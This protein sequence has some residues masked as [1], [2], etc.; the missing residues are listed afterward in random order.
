LPGSATSVPGVAA[1]VELEQ[2][3]DAEPRQLAGFFDRAPERRSDAR[4]AL[5]RRAL[6]STETTVLDTPQLVV[7]C[8]PG[9]AAPR[10]ADHP[11]C[12]VDGYVHNAGELAGQLELPPGSTQE[13]TLLA[14]FAR[15]GF[16]MLERLRGEFAFVLWDPVARRGMLA[17]DQLGTRLLVLR[18][19][20]GRLWFASEVRE[21]LRLL[22]RRPSPDQSSLAN[23]LVMRSPADGCTMFEG[24]R[25]LQPGHA[26]LLDPDG[27]RV[28]RYWA[29]RYHEPLR[30]S[31]QEL[32]E[33]VR[34]RLY[35]S[36]SRR[37]E[38]TGGT[39]VMMSGGLDS[40]SLA[41]VAH[42]IAPGSVLTASVQFPEYPNVDET[43]YVDCINRTLGMPSVKVRMNGIGG[44]VY[45]AAEYLRAWELP[46]HAWSDSWS[47]PLTDAAGSH[48]ARAIFGGDGGD[49]VFGSRFYLM[50]DRIRAGNLRGAVRLV[51][52]LA[53]VGGIP[54][55]DWQL[56]LLGRFGL[57]PALPWRAHDLARRLHPRAGGSPAWLLPR[58]AARLSETS[59]PWGWLKLDGPRWWAGLVNS[60]VSG[61]QQIGLFD[62]IRR[63]AAR[64]GLDARHALYDL[65]LL[66]LAFRLPP[67]SC[68]DAS[69]SRPLLRD[70]VA[71]VSPDEVRL[72]PDKSVFDAP[73]LDGIQGPEREAVHAI[74]GAPDAEILAYVSRKGLSGLLRD[75]APER[76]ERPSA[77]ALAVWRLTTAEMWL[78]AEADPS[79]V[80]R[81]L[82]S[83]SIARPNYELSRPQSDFFP[84]AARHNPTFSGLARG[85]SATSL[86]E[87]EVASRITHGANGRR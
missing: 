11:W 34:E 20:G 9:L 29:P 75:D 32:V 79:V 2:R 16:A 86:S 30:A 62:E 1:R 46:L 48:G 58:T 51:R 4:R 53:E 61:P 36:V 18:A 74:L 23:W 82:T 22:P 27:W 54:P 5:V 35:V 71:G 52:R 59:D 64:S 60:V 28:R 45:S 47:R 40:T 76:Y 31:R 56:R 8:A 55:R 3:R 63:R 41:A 80:D 33:L 14:A 84:P 44:M 17:R 77:W 73:I 72:R 69:L 66:E 26:V 83:D 43:F 24:V 42:D 78:R 81:W 85:A 50:A 6:G 12:L 19:D 7:G 49:E 68:F 15:W 39:A 37:I 13:A 10:H 25:V 87:D 57:T 70:A 67:L 65:D 21:L 38:L